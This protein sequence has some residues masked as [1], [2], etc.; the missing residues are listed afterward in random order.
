MNDEL[1]KYLTQTYRQELDDAKSK[2]RQD[3]FGDDL[4]LAGQ[5]IGA[6]FAPGVKVDQTY[7]DR[8][9]TQNQQGVKDVKDTRATAVENYKIGRQVDEDTRQDA[10]RKGEDDPKSET[11]KAY[12][13]AAAKLMPGK[14]FSGMN[15]T[16]LKSVI[17]P[18]KDIYD[19]DQKATER[20]EDTRAKRDLVEA[21]RLRSDASLGLQ[22]E[23][24]DL[25]K[26]KATSSGSGQKITAGTAKEVGEIDAA[27]A[28]ADS[29]WTSYEKNARGFGSG[30]KAMLPGA[31]AN[32][33]EK[34]RDVAAQT[35]GGILEGG[36]LTE[37]DYARY[38][39]M[40]PGPGDTNEQAQAKYQ[41][42]KSLINEKRKGAIGGLSASG[43]DTSGFSQSPA[44]T[45]TA[46]Q[47]KVINGA[48]YQ[49]VEGGWKAVK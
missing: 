21:T 33:Y 49:K 37:Q 25:D 20:R 45:L 18:Y 17:D 41:A 16:Q 24:L 23:R 10:T 5:Q 13:A 2:A 29:L 36:K 39:K 27:V 40:L 7:F 22:R 48:T 15:A 38:R 8:Q 19:I 42:I 14:D 43:F 35:I 12:Q 4:L 6:A 30:L 47:T 32:L 3:Q 11:S 31:D 46:P 9:A 26:F 34:G 28:M 1:K 44:S